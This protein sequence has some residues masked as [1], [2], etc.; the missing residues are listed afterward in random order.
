MRPSTL[1]SPSQRPRRTQ[2]AL[3]AALLLALPSACSKDEPKNDRPPP[4][5]APPSASAQAD[6]CAS[7]GGQDTDAISAPFVPRAAG[8]Y[9]IDPQSEPKTYGDKGKLSMDE[10]CTT[11]FDGECEVYKRFDLDRVVVL[12]Y[13]DGSGAPNS[14]EVNL[15]RFKSVDGA[16]AMFTKRVVADA[17]PAETVP[18]ALDAGGGPEPPASA[19]RPCWRSFS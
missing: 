19:M 17:D 2:R 7:G 11:A 4:P 16:F 1:V 14:I 12:R 18:A 6:L 8:G 10:V 5:S 9:C 13:V 3:L 15:S